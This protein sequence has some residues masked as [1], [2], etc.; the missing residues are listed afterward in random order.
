MEQVKGVHYSLVSFCGPKHPLVREIIK[1]KE[2]LREEKNKAV[3]E[4]VDDSGTGNSLRSGTENSDTISKELD[5]SASNNHEI[6]ISKRRI[7]YCIIYLAPGDYHWFHSPTDWTIE[8]R[9]HIPG[10]LRNIPS[11]VK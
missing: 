5:V 11:F 7:Y 10:M 1:N 9:R 6:D 4:L 8:H 2:K 3:D